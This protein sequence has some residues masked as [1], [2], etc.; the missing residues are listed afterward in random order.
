MVLTEAEVGDLMDGY[1][2]VLNRAR[3]VLTVLADAYGMP[4]TLRVEQL[5]SIDQ[6]IVQVSGYDAALN[7]HAVRVFPTTY[8]WDNAW[9]D[10]LGR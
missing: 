4:N 6:H 10:A 7:A 5:D 1:T 2:K 8:L 9:A 3:E